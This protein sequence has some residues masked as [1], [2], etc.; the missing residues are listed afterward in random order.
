MSRSNESTI[1][2]NYHLQ[3]GLKSYDSGLFS[4]KPM[5]SKAFSRASISHRPASNKRATLLPD[6][7]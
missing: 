3:C 6:F 4:V 7:K 5:A 1:R 2:V